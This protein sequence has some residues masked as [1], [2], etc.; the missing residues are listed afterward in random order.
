LPVRALRPADERDRFARR[1]DQLAD[2][3]RG[4]GRR[5]GALG[6]PGWVLGYTPAYQVGNILLTTWGTIIV[7]VIGG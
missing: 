3:D 1:L 2:R 4:V 7:L 6:E 5:T